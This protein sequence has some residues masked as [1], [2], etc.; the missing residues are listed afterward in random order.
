MQRAQRTAMAT[1]PPA[2]AP[3]SEASVPSTDSTEPLLRFKKAFDFHKFVRDHLLPTNNADLE[4]T[5]LSSARLV[6]QE[7]DGGV[8]FV[9]DTA[10][11]SEGDAEAGEIVTHVG[12]YSQSSPR[13]R[14]LYRHEFRACICAA[15][16]NFERTLLA[17]T[18]QSTLEDEVTYEPFVA[19]IQPQGRVFS[20]NM[21]GGGFRKLQFLHLDMTT[22][23][24]RISRN[25][26]SSRLLL[27]I[28][29]K[30]VCLYTFKMQMLREGAVLTQQ[31]EQEV[32]ADDFS[33]YQWDPTMQR[34]YYARFETTHSRVQA[35]VSGRN[36]LVIN[37]IAF[38]S[39]S[40]EVLLTVSLP[41]PYNERVYST[42]S[43]YYR[44][45]FAFTLPVREMN[46]QVL[47]RRDGYWCI[48]L[49]HCTGVA[50][51]VDDTSSEY[52][53]PDGPQ[54]GKIDYSVYIVHNGY[55][56]Y[57]QVP[58][59]MPSSEDLYI[60]FMLIGCFVAAYIPG[61]MLHL[62]NVGPRTD[63]CHHLA[64]GPS[65]TPEFPVE[66]SD[67]D[68]E[69][70][71]SSS[72]EGPILSLAISSFLLGDYNTAVMECNS[73]VLYE[74]GLNVARFMALFKQTSSSDLRESLLHLMV[75][76]FRHNA[77]ALSM[78]EH[79]CH[80]PMSLAD[81]RL[82]AEYM[83]SA[84]F[85]GVYFDC[86]RYMA[87][88]LPLTLTPTFRGK[89]YK[90]EDRS[91]LALL[92]V[93]PM[94]NFIQQLMIQSDQKLVS[95][96]PDDLLNN[97]PPSD[98][99]LEMLCHTV[100]TS[101]A[102]IARIDFR[103]IMSGQVESASGAST[104]QASP[105]LPQRGR[106]SRKSQEF[107]SSSRT[108]RNVFNNLTRRTPL[109][110]RHA[111]ANTRGELVEMLQFLEADE[112]QTMLMNDE[113][114]RIREQAVMRLG[115][116]V[117]LRSRNVIFTSLNAYLYELEKQSCT[118]LLLI[119]QS[120]SFSSDS[121]P[122]RETIHRKATIKEQILFEL[123]EAYHLA[124]MEIG[125]PVPA[126]FHTLYT[127]L[128]FICLDHILFLQYLRNGVFNAT[129]KFLDL[130][131]MDPASVK[132][133]DDLVYQIIS[134]MDL[135]KARYALDKWS[136]SPAVRCLTNTQ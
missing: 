61:F 59:P 97:H 40:Q 22:P 15:S 31:P 6:G 68:D 50:A 77:M 136:C 107:T 87:K 42:S 34:L 26:L 41:L 45:P 90:N 4:K 10:V 89:V 84:A 123:L 49:Q 112:E 48:C 70:V 51:A 73:E 75:M 60:H 128:G 126:G 38:S 32:I 131:F 91:N 66:V 133:D 134:Q 39:S 118:L 53:D 103:S 52:E 108:L 74:C 55:V 100:I 110:G 14:V 63:P 101:N 82:F 16:V 5:V 85:A 46:L 47:Q 56:L 105:T 119:W 27:I 99:P 106:Q 83:L 76:G 12:W 71:L 69:G 98:H 114:S 13:Y 8:L 67:S 1:S 96:N 44:S 20:L 116:G 33:W 104:L 72:C 79:V 37:C 78:L 88:Q 36:S 122:L 115:T 7:K 62:L 17:F 125:F 81:H 2:S 24:N 109:A 129:K 94:Q 65:L 102:K 80:T 9:W 92:K 28:P 3:T 121:H 11:G 111:L 25:V 95:Q 64:F 43:T 135:A 130:F 132:L 19:E 93:S 124:H 23:R 58:L 127:A 120:L 113:V 29:D 30:C 54:G 86:K 21:S 117:V 35:S 57:G 18:I